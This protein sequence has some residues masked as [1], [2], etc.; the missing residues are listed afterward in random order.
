MAI[1]RK[2]I[3]ISRDRRSLKYAIEGIVI[4]LL[5]DW[6]MNKMYQTSAASLVT[7]FKIGREDFRTPGT[8]AISSWL[9]QPKPTLCSEINQH[10]CKTAFVDLDIDGT[11][12]AARELLL[13][14]SRELG[15]CRH[16]QCK[17]HYLLA[18][19]IY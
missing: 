10:V 17:A 16:A 14:P 6:C 13:A 5:L 1:K 3:Y 12:V 8:W 18:C 11:G 4:S 7:F 15:H 19:I 9:T 2:K